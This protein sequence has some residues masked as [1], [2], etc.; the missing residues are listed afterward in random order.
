MSIIHLTKENFSREV[1]ESSQPVLVDFFATWCGPCKMIA[2]MLEELD[3]EGH[4]FKI[5]KLDVDEQQELAQQFG[6]MSI[7]TLIV[8]KDGKPV[9]TEIGFKPKQ[10]ILDMTK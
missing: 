3:Q 10:A 8:F 5:A 1:L 2:P 9:K 4:D 7:P 6:V